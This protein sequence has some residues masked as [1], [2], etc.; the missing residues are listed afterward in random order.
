VCH[1]LVA[2]MSPTKPP[3]AVVAYHYKEIR[4]FCKKKVTDTVCPDPNCVQQMDIPPESID[5]GNTVQEVATASDDAYLL[6]KKS[7][8]ISFRSDVKQQSVGFFWR[9]HI[10]QIHATGQ[11]D[12]RTSCVHY[13][14]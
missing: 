13:D 11:T 3:T 1:G 9:G 12:Q 7:C 6:D 8:Q 4:D 14:L 5:S 10:T 2:A